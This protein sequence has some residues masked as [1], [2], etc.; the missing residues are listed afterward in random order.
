MRIKKP[1]LMLCLCLV[2]F[3]PVSYAKVSQE[4]Q[5]RKAVPSDALG[6][7]RIPS[8]WGFLSAPKGNALNDALKDDNH[9]LE[10]EGL[11]ESIGKRFGELAG[12]RLEPV[13]NLLVVQLASPI[14]IF[15][16][17]PDNAPLQMA[18]ILASANLSIDSLE[19]FKNF[20]TNMVNAAPKLSLMEEVSSDGYAVLATEGMPIFLHYAPET[21]LLNAMVGITVNDEVLRDRI[22]ASQPAKDHPMYAFEKEIDESGQGLFLWLNV[23]KLMPTIQASI[24]PGNLETLEKWGLTEIRNLAFGWGVSRGNGRLKLSIEGPKAGYRKL[25]PGIENNFSVWASGEPE[26]VFTL[27]LPLQEIRDGLKTL[28]EKERIP[29]ILEILDN[30]DKFCQAR[31]SMPLNDVLEAFGPELILFTDEIDSLFALRIKNREKMTTLLLNISNQAGASMETTEHDGRRYHH[32]ILPSMVSFADSVQEETGLSQRLLFELLDSINTHLYW[33]EED[34]YL[35]FA[36]VPQALFDRADAENRVSIQSWIDQHQDTTHSVL[37][38]S[39]RFARIPSRLYY[40]YLEVITS[41]AD[42]A[43]YKIDIFSLPSARQADLPSEGVY[44]IQ[45]DLSDTMASLTFTF[46]NNPLEFLMAQNAAMTAAALGVITAIAVPNFIE[47]RARAFDSAANADVKNA[48]TAAQAYFTDY[49]NESVTIEKLKQ[50]GFRPTEGVVLEIRNGSQED[51]SI[52]S[53]HENGKSVYVVDAMGR[54]ERY[55]R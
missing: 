1:W 51:L 41:F 27:S 48:Y 11:K 30:A 10:L 25:F 8:I 12:R 2:L 13:I 22:D 40:T 52:T 6:Y 36:S 55:D 38:L 9:V 50:A 29:S 45:L 5:L 35:I 20:L 14:E 31:L 21:G 16:E 3:A 46:E 15:L 19:S 28:G 32:L 23:N 26:T 4:P 49:P 24:A 34:G 44:G 43:D 7:I 39:T 53:Y 42:M 37:N 18:T 47:Y 33:T 54:I 17:L